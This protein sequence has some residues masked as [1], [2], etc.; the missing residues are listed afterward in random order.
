MNTLA[1]VSKR[2]NSDRP[3]TPNTLTPRS[4]TDGLSARPPRHMRLMGTPMAVVTEA[5][6]VQTIL[7][8][9]EA[10]QGHWTITAN[11]DHLRRYHSNPIE[12][13]LIDDADLIVADGM[14]LIW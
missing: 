6:A 9:A 12:K 13:E 11:L 10:C 14:P 3:S 2:S 8:A 1:T 4:S 5:S 7:D